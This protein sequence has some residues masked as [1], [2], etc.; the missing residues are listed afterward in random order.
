MTLL[1]SMTDQEITFA[2]TESP[3]GGYE[4]RAV[5]H[6]IFTHVDTVDELRQEVREAV[7]CHFENGAAPVTIRFRGARDEVIGA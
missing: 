1:I 2:V 3:E 6:A 7:H 5:G 4:A